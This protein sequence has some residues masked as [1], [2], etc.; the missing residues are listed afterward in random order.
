MEIK[1]MSVPR[2]PRTASPNKSTRNKT[3]LPDVNVTDPLALI[4]KP[5]LAA[6]LNVSAWTID[7]WRKRKTIPQPIRLSGQVVAWRR[8]AIS[9]WLAQ[10]EVAPAPAR[11]FPTRKRTGGAA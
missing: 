2:T 6:L 11:S 7:G 9:D 5:E 4:R 3:N 1:P 8:S 10:R